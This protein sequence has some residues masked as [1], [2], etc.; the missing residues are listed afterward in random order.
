MGK[1]FFVG[2]DLGE[3]AGEGVVDFL[4]K[5]EVGGE[6]DVEVALLDL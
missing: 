6:E 3:F 5:G 2:E 1:E 4:H